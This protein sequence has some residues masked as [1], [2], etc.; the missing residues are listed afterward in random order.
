MLT[1]TSIRWLVLAVSA[2][3]LLAVVAACSSETIEVPGETVVVEKEVVKT[4]EVPGETVVKEVIKEVQVPG[5]T[6][7]VKEE[8]VKEVMVPGETVVVEKEV[9]KTVEVPG[10]T[11]TVEVVKT[12]EVP[13]E[14]VVVEKEVVKTV[15]VPGETVVIEKQVPVEVV[16]TVEVPGQKYVTDPSTG[17]AVVAPQYGG[18]ITYAQG[19]EYAGPDTVVSGIW[20]QAYVAGVT[21]KLAMSDWATPRDEFDFVSHN[22]PNNTI[23]QLAESWS[24]PDPLTYIVKVRPGVHWHDKPPMNGRVLTAD[25]IVI[26]YH[27]ITGTGSGFTEPSDFALSLNLPFDSITATDDSTVVFKLKEPNLGG[28]AAILDG[29]IAWIYPPEV[30]KEH[31][32][33][34]DWRNL[35]GTGPMMLT[36]WVEGSSVTWDKNP[37]YWGYDEKYPENRLPYSDRLRVLFVNEVATRLAALRTGKIDYIGPIG[38]SQLMTLDQVES[39]RQTNPELVIHP[40]INRS[41]NGIGMNVQVEPFGDIRVRKAMQMAI[42]LKEINRAFYG[43]YADMTPQGQLNRS[44]A[45]VVT[46]FEDWPEEVKKVFDFDPEGAEALLDEA[47]H[48]RGADGIRFKTE[49]MW[50]DLRP[51]SY[52][53]LL[54]SYWKRIGVDV[55]VDVEAIAPFAARRG[56]RDFEMISAEAAGRGSPLGWQSRY[57][58]TAPWN[59]SNVND[60]WYTAKYEAGGAATTIEEYNRIVGELNQYGIEKFW[61]IWGGLAPQYVAVQPWLIGFNGETLLG[62]GQYTTIFTRLWIDQ[63]LKSA[64]G[65]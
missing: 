28:L 55:E 23:G 32:D 15:E 25:D 60:P 9:V 26:N 64:M 54:A 11:V 34:T 29:N 61:T 40:Y 46:Q 17:K 48:E 33:V 3:M 12:V 52:A 47:G 62:I 65:H 21:E 50:L 44:F 39:L 19:A 41:D 18:T 31:G 37:D 56:E 53:E 42:N 7:V 16:K 51:V 35:V 43:G 49:L 27:R 2:A 24:Q 10:E 45:E 38:G 57:T 36:D 4:V 13:G 8:V 59:S 22:V 58:P 5:E 14:T 20:A 30:I 1:S 63:E 6:V